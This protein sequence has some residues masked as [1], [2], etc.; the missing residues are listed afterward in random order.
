MSL[1]MGLCA[2]PLETLKGAPYEIPSNPLDLFP[3]RA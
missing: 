3:Y 1:S 2:N